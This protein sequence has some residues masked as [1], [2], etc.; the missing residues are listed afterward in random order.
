MTSYAY[1]RPKPG[2]NHVRM[3]IAKILTG[4]CGQAVHGLRRPPDGYDSVGGKVHNRGVRVVFD[5]MQCYPEYIITVQLI[6]APAKAT[7]K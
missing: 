6:S 1:C 5:R 7:T 2:E 4:K 3:F